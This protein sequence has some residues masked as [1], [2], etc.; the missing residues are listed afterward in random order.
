[1]PSTTIVPEPISIGADNESAPMEIVP[2]GYAESADGESALV[3][4]KRRLTVSVLGV[5]AYRALGLSESQTRRNQRGEEA[6][7]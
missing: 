1:M 3:L 7:I 2:E 5:R 4:P 6:D